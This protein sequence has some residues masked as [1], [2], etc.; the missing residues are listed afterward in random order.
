[1]QRGNLLPAGQLLNDFWIHRILI[2]ELSHPE[3]GK[4]N[5]QPAESTEPS[6]AE[7]IKEWIPQSLRF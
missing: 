5:I 7:R 1:M 3:K 2:K 4:T 6:V